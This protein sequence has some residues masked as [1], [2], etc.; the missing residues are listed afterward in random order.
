MYSDRERSRVLREQGTSVNKL[1]QQA[2]NQI[3][4]NIKECMEKI[5]NKY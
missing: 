2:E 5:G 3:E 1:A 4:K